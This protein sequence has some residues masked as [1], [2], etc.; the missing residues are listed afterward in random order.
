MR[1]AC[2]RRISLAVVAF[3][4]PLLAGCIPFVPVYYAYPT[5]AHVPAIPADAPPVEVRAFRVEVADQ[6]NCIDFSDSEEDRYLL[7]EVSL[8]G[9]GKVPAQTLVAIDHGW[10]WNGLAL[11]CDGHT[12]HTVMVR[13]YRPGWQTVEVPSWQRTG[14]VRWKP[15]ADAAERERA[16]DDLLSTWGTDNKGQLWKHPEG[17]GSSANDQALPPRDA[18]VFRSL[19]P[20]V[21]VA[22]S[23]ASAGLRGIGVR[24]AGE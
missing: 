17:E 8:S 1:I 11:S 12:R 2:V 24:A 21:G 22:T 9:A 14:Q 7:S 16:V 5:M 6:H 18:T 15:A 13:L 19:A 23:P 20:R 3:L 4:G 10:I